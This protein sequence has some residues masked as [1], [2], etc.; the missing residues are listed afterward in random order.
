MCKAL[1]ILAIFFLSTQTLCAQKTYTVSFYDNNIFFGDRQGLFKHQPRLP[2]KYVVLDY[3]DISKRRIW[4]VFYINEDGGLIDKEEYCCGFEEIALKDAGGGAAGTCIE[5]DVYVLNEIIIYGCQVKEKD[6]VQV[7]SFKKNG[8]FDKPLKRYAAR[9]SKL[10]PYT[11]TLQQMKL[12]Y[13]ALSAARDYEIVLNTDTF[14][15]TGINT[16]L[17]RPE[18]KV[19]GDFCT[20]YSYELNGKKVI[21]N[22]ITLIK[23][24]YET[25][26]FSG[27]Y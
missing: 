26:Y 10:L 11:D 23:P 14:R 2:G 20:M 24:G 4:R 6:V 25:R 17:Y 1:C 18:N 8:R 15:I 22:F 21:S 5:Q 19:I 12:D 9:V 3:G 7:R 16:A 13:T 27:R